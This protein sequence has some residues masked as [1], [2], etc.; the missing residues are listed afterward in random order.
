MQPLSPGIAFGCIE[1]LGVVKRN[2]LTPG[3]VHSLSLGSVSSSAIYRACL[4]LSW[5]EV[6]PNG[7]LVVTARGEIAA[8]V[9]SPQAGLRTMLVDFI[10][11]EQPPWLQLVPY[12]RRE[13]LLQAPPSI[14]QVFVE[15]GLAYGDD[16]E[17]VRFW[18]GLA[19][20]ARGLRDDVLTEIGRRGERLTLQHERN[21][22]G[23][24]PKWIAIES[25][26]DGY[27]VLSRVS[28]SDTRRM[29]IEVK[30]S[31]QDTEYASFH[32]TRNEWQTAIGSM[33]HRFHLWALARAKDELAVL[34]VE[35]VGAH[36]PEDA[37]AGAWETL[38]VPFS[39]FK[40]FFREFSGDA[41]Q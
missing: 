35:Q 10:E 19:A 27:D 39:A 18:D 24:E 21:R 14:R 36:V 26:S 4:D 29:T 25:S 9:V 11:V 12:G 1:L 5:I 30:A 23:V 22:T 15:A 34:T 41:D 6:G 16:E 33:A 8:S 7:L 13:T 38:R 20:R 40:E 37:G 3:G 31:E 32:L 28:A 2:Q 17:T